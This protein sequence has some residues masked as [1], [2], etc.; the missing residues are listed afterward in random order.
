MGYNLLQ[1]RIL[2]TISIQNQLTISKYEY[3][4]LDILWK[5]YNYLRGHAPSTWRALKLK[6]GSAPADSSREEHNGV[7]EAC[8]ME[9]E[10]GWMASFDLSEKI[11]TTKHAYY[12]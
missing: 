3:R 6:D 10:Q 9:G 5:T 4:L 8:G 2:R 11:I 12:H 1:Y 7:G